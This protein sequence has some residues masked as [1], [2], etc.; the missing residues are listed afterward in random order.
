[1]S[2]NND[3]NDE[4]ET[5]KT[6]LSW[7]LNYANVNGKQIIIWGL[8]EQLSLVNLLDHL[9]SIFNLVSAKPQIC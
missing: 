8:N 3:K 5:S 4:L 6:L 9:C 2:T 7:T 1:M